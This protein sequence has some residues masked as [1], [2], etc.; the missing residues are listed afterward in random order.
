MQIYTDGYRSIHQIGITIYKFVIPGLSGGGSGSGVVFPSGSAETTVISAEP[1]SRRMVVK[2]VRGRRRYTAFEVPPG[3][4][5]EDVESVLKSSGIEDFKVITCSGGYAVVRTPPR[6]C[7]G[8]RDAMAML[9]P[10]VRSLKTSGTL[11]TLRDRF[12]F[13]RVRQKRKR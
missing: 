4:L 8:L 12:P 2:S 7:A 3:T 9:D 10:G 5:R 11:R 13:L 6:G 1:L